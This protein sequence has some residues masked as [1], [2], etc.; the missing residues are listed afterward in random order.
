MDRFRK[1]K[2][3]LSACVFLFMSCHFVKQQQ[4]NL[5]DDF[6]IVFLSAFEKT[7]SS[8][9]D[10]EYCFDSEYF[11]KYFEEKEELLSL[12]YRVKYFDADTSL[13]LFINN[14]TVKKYF[15]N[16][17]PLKKAYTE[18][19]EI[20]E[21]LD[22]SIY[23]LKCDYYTL[24]ENIHFNHNYV[25]A[26]YYL[27]EDNDI[28]V[29]VNYKEYGLGCDVNIIKSFLERFNRSVFEFMQASNTNHILY[30]VVLP[31]LSDI[32]PPPP[33]YNGTLYD[34]DCK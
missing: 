29:Y 19:T 23:F 31:C 7:W 3:F 27:M 28:N 32:P 11:F 25:Y 2:I 13:V 34:N 5:D 1:I 6:D 10:Y 18:N 33:N 4:V 14:D 16:I 30:K 17:K 12:G 21:M 22:E 24:N 15:F 20:L 9:F 8:C 26:D